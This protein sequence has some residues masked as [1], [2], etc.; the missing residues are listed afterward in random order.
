M[1]N[2]ELVI[3]GASGHA[4]VV[5]STAL[6]SNIPILGFLDDKATAPFEGYRILGNTA[7]LSNYTQATIAIGRN[8]IRK[9]IA[10]IAPKQFGW[11]TLIHPSTYVH[12]SASIGEGTVIFA[13]AIIQPDARIGKHCIVN[14]GVTIDHD[15]DIGDYVHLAPGTHLAGGVTIGE[16]AFLG[17][18]TNVIQEMAIGDWVTVGA[19]GVV[20]TPISANK[21]VVGVPAREK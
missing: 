19:G 18:G 9:K 13:G 3:I 8:D 16:G 7:Q 17:I 20:V 5:L 6:A 11:K 12:P 1:Q 2:Q 4:K 21:I 15:C 14:T 10:A